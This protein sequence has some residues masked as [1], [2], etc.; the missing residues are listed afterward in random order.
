MNRIRFC[1]ILLAVEWLLGAGLCAWAQS[2]ADNPE[3]A[4]LIQQAQS[5][6]AAAQYLLGF[7]YAEG[8]QLPQDWSR[9]AYWYR[10]AALAGDA[11]AQMAL[12]ALYEEGRGV[13]SNPDK[14]LFWYRQAALSANGWAQLFLSLRLADTQPVFSYLWALLAELNGVDASEQKKNLLAKKEQ[15]LLVDAQVRLG[16]LVRRHP[17][18]TERISGQVRYISEEEGFSVLFPSPPVQHR[19]EHD[20]NSYTVYFQAAA[21]DGRTVYHLTVRQFLSDL[22]DSPSFRQSFVQD[23]LAARARISSDGRLLRQTTLYFGHSAVLF[24]HT[25]QAAEGRSIHQGLLV[26]AGR[27]F[28]VLTCIF[29][30]TASTPDFQSFVHSLDFPQIGCGP[31]LGEQPNL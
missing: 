21:A 30:E 26:F 3:T 2:A 13:P 20:P 12:A 5:G 11:D 7:L 18:L 28:L 24:K 1:G 19:L 23:Y 6:D 17:Y 29:P 25:A 4:V 9:A 10:A 14:A 31:L 16:E 22:A 27:T 8:R 15:D